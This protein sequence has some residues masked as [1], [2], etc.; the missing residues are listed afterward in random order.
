MRSVIK[1][2]G[3]PQV[4]IE[5]GPEVRAAVPGTRLLQNTPNPFSKTTT[6]R[7]ILQDADVR[8]KIM[9]GVYDA[10]GR[11]IETLIDGYCELV[12]STAFDASSLPSGVYFLRLDTSG[13]RL[14][15]KMVIL[16]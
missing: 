15:R 3:C 5:E 1:W 13:Q 4:G 6:I 11:L 10:S 7:I 2:L 16:R 14:C 9:L 12:F 8:G